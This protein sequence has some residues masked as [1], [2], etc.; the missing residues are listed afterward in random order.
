MTYHHSYGGY[1]EV[2]TYEFTAFTEADLLQGVNGGS[3][4]CG[5]VFTMPAGATTCFTVED[6]DGTLSGDACRNESG[7][8]RSYQTADIEVNGEPVFGDVKIYAEQY[9]VL[10]GS[11]GKTYY[12][13]EI[14]VKNEDAPGE[15]DDFFTF[16][17]DVPP[18]GV[19]LT[20]G[21]A[22]NVK[23]NWL[24]YKR[25]DAGVCWQP[26]GD[27]CKFTVE[28]ESLELWGY[29]SEW[30]DAASGD[31]LIKLKSDVGYAKMDF[32]GE[33]GEYD[34]EICYVD[35]NDGQGFI[36]IF[37]N[38]EF[39][40]CISLNQDNNGNGVHN[41]TFSS[42]VIED[43]DLKEGDQIKLKGRGDGCEF[44]RID[45]LVFSKCDDNKD[46]TPVEDSAKLCSD[47]AATIDVLAND[48]DADGDALTITGIVTD[49]GD[50]GLFG[51]ADD[52]A[53]TPVLDGETVTLNSGATVTLTGGQLVYDV[54]G[55][56]D[57]FDTLEIGQTATDAFGYTVD[58][59]NGGV[60]TAAV[61]VELCGALNT[62]ET[63]ADSLPSTV[64]FMV[65][66]ALAT[67]ISNS[68][69]FTITITDSGDARLDGVV[70]EEAY[71]LS[72]FDDFILDTPLA[73]ELF[74]ADADTIPAG[75]L[76]QIGAFG[77]AARDNVDLINFILNQDFGN[78]DSGTL[79]A[80]GPTV[81]GENYTDA[82]IQAAVWGLTDD[83]AFIGGLN[84][85]TLENAQEIIDFAAANGEGFEAGE[86]D[87]V[88]L[89]IDPTDDA[90][91]LGH[92]QP[93]IIGVPFD[94]LKLDC[95]CA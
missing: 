91:A 28:A 94:D 29:K 39:V 58:D 31:K 14:E 20:V 13:I 82:E 2:K 30:N 44:A 36:D 9:H 73:G 10:S 1:S 21:N 24:D 57:D 71:C 61:D 18:A 74:L 84:N 34:I 50:D 26:E 55:D 40:D 6:N 75:A 87:I 17:G 88:G 25:L 8:D 27:D 72:I 63:I 85:G 95:L 89:F 5:D 83:F 59:G 16:Y 93:F 80:G 3:I 33:D 76:D 35:E 37:V 54:S 7:D 67:D 42:F 68:E 64:T 51:T 78:V 66:D 86:G 22:C 77:N 15:G 53:A 38:G 11:D 45:K 47:A 65:E 48:T 32:G 56:G 49:A 46:P 43:I 81:S 19:E 60:A 4:G 79:D 92:T 70:F 52:V 12:L 69:A 90:N 41:T 23:G 62:L